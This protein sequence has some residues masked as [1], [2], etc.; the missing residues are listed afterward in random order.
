MQRQRDQAAEPKAALG[1]DR[2]EVLRREEAVVAG[3]RHLPAGV[4][5]PSQQGYAERAG[6]G[7]GDRCG[8]E[9]PHV[10]ALPGAGNLQQGRHIGVVAGS[11]VRGGVAAPVAAVLAVE[12]AREQ[13][14]GIVGQ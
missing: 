10:R 13:S 2:L 3:Q 8:E 7:G 11:D 1:L 12:V 4:D 14:A 6:R 5:R 9:R